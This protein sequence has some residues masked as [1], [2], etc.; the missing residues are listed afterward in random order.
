M[1][2]GGSFSGGK[3]AGRVDDH[4]PPCN[5]EVKNCGSIPLLPHMPSWQSAQ[6]NKHRSNFTVYIYIYIVYFRAYLIER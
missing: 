4:S 6:I 2:T 3:A 1:D 5:A